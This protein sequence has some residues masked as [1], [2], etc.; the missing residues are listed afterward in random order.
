MI[1]GRRLNLFAADPAGESERKLVAE[2]VFSRLPLLNLISSL[3]H[4]TLVPAI[5]VELLTKR[6]WYR[7][8]AGS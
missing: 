2:H 3:F 6:V 8:V 5:V 4:R 1:A 7:T